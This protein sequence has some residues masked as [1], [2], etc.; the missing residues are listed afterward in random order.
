MLPEF[1][2]DKITERRGTDSLKWDMRDNDII[3]LWVADMDFESPQEVINAIVKRAEH[4]IYGYTLESQGLYEAVIKWVNRRHNWF[5]DKDWIVFTPGVMPGIRGILK[6]LTTPGDNVIIQSPVY[7]PFFTAI[8][9]RGCHV[10]NNPLQYK[11]GRYVMDLLDLE[12]KAKDPRTKIMIL[13]SPHNPVGRAWT[14]EELSSVGKICEKHGVII[15]SD[16][17]HCDL[18][19]KGYKHIPLA[20]ICDGCKEKIITCISPS[21]T[22]NLAGLKTAFLI[23]PNPKI[24][25]EFKNL[26]LP[27]QPEIFGS[28]GAEIAYNTGDLWVDAMLDYVED[29]QKFVVNRLQQEIPSIKCVKGEGTYLTWLDCRGLGMD[30]ESLEKFMLDDVGLWVNQGYSFGLGGEGFV[31]MNIGCRRALIEEALI[32]LQRAA[33]EIC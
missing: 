8:K 33:Q 31:R 26:F 28:I 9:N 11:N 15:I 23:I 6:I 17:I 18:V 13:C 7:P 24:R 27:K 4:G 21:K 19:Y 3:P 22:F 12:E 29:N 20:S 25:E 32:R 10:V 16:D 30:N 14:E 1:N 2:F 5:I